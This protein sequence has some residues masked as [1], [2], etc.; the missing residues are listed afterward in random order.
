[1]KNTKA[2]NANNYI[3]PALP[4]EKCRDQKKTDTSS[5]TDPKPARCSAI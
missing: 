1:V 5:Y 2:G 3:S 4:T